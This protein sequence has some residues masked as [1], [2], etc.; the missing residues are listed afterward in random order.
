MQPYGT[1]GGVRLDVAEYNDEGKI[2][3]IYDL[4]TGSAGLTDAR[5]Q[6]IRD[7]VKEVAIPDVPIIEIHP[8]RP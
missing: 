6:Q 5:I 1:A 7:A 2:C 3:A 4:K 8:N